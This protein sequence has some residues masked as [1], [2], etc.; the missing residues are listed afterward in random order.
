MTPWTW[1]NR[2][3]CPS[4]FS[5][6]F[7]NSCPLSQ[8]CYLTI[9]SS[10]TPF[11]CLQ[12]LPASGSFPLGS[13]HYVDKA[14]ELQLQNQSFQWIFRVNF[15]QNWLFFLLV[16]QGTCKSLLQHH[17]S[18]TSVLRCSYFFVVQ[19]SHPYMT[20]GKNIVLTIQTFAAKVISPLF[21]T[22]CLP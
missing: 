19:P 2:L 1:P 10:A 11:F 7:T 18:K 3:P 4:L 20:T 21:N 16:I 14:L 15:L 5:E 12:S 9:S 8:W 6:V 17:Y 13:S 22:L